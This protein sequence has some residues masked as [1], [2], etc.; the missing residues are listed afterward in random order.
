MRGSVSLMMLGVALAVAG[1]HKQADSSNAAATQASTQQIAWREGDVDD[2]FAE[3][4]EAKKPVLLYWGAKW[5]PP[6]NLMKQTLFK[7]PAFIAETANF[8]PVHLDGDAKD[9]QLWGEKFGIQGY[10]TVIILTPDRQE[11]TRL[12]GGSTAGQL[13]DVLKVAA[14]RTSST[15]DLLKRADNP[16]SLS[17]DDWRLLASF[18]WFDD[19]KHFGDYKQTGTYVG[20][21]AAAAPD[22]AMKRHFA[23]TGLLLASGM[24]DKP[25]LTA[26]QQAQVRAILPAILANYDEV[27][28]N[29]QE[30]GSAA[31]LVLA[32]PDPAE[33]KALGDTLT[34]AL[35]RMAADDS[36][37]LYDRLATAEAEITLSKG[38]ND[39][40]VTPDVMAKVR[41]R[42][43]LAD[44]TAID[45]QM[46]Q[47]V[48]PSAGDLLSEAGD[49]AGAEAL[50][51]AELPKAVAP[52]YFMVDLAGLKEDAKD[53]PAA[54]GWLKQAAE[55]AQGP[56]T[57]IQ[58]AIFYSNGVM[59]MTPDDKA[60]VEQSA[61]MVI[62]TLG[63]NSSGYAERTEKKSGDWAKKLRDWSGKHSGADVLARLDAK[64]GQVCA[65][66]GCKDVLKA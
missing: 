39:G 4:K 13:A 66:G 32:L 63:Q 62:D 61:G 54:I 52:Y 37:P 38:E 10:P 47:A 16:A 14:T 25:K 18:D 24:D 35:D 15:E 64:M 57:R 33:Q 60:A 36:I 45:P 2:A 44:K 53:Y 40:K 48:M 1:C 19:P 9:A 49:K 65:K 41:Q 26:D 20:K 12:S 34:A 43:A 58:W 51:K 55:T 3:A 5:C 11:V 22:P 50:W 23:L 17:A 46:R 27:K 28:A 7:D 21:L 59:R 29:R 42:V 30:V 56:A 6:C 8:I 31:G